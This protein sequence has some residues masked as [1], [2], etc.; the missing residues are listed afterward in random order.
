[1]EHPSFAF[2]IFVCSFNHTWIDNCIH[3]AWKAAHAQVQKSTCHCQFSTYK[4]ANGQ[5]TLKSQQIARSE[6]ILNGNIFDR[7]PWNRLYE[8]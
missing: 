6:M 7:T 1:M 2:F 5:K 4:S 8:S 3:Y